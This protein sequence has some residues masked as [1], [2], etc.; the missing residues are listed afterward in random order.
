MSRFAGAACPTVFASSRKTSLADL[1]AALAAKEF[2]GAAF[3]G[4]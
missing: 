2:I 4:S 1:A 3:N